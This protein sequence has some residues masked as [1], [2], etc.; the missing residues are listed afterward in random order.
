[1]FVPLGQPAL[2]G[3]VS[4]PGLGVDAFKTSMELPVSVA[5]S[6]ALDCI[7]GANTA[8]AGMIQDSVP[9]QNVMPRDGVLDSHWVNKLGLGQHKLELA[10]PHYQQLLAGGAY[11]T[12]LARVSEL[13]MFAQESIASFRQEDLG[14]TLT[15]E[16][17]MRKDW[18]TGF[19]GQSR[20][21]GELVESIANSPTK[22]FS[23]APEMAVLSSLSFD[24]AAALMEGI[25]VSE[26]SLREKD[27]IFR[28]REDAAAETA[29]A[30]EEAIAAYDAGFVEMLRGARDALR[31]NPDRVRHYSISMREL[32]NRLLSTL[33]PDDAIRR[34]SKDPALYHDGKPTRAARV[35]YICRGGKNAAYCAYVDADV[36]EAIR[37]VRD[38]QGM[39]HQPHKRYSESQIGIL[40]CRMESALRVVVSNATA[41]N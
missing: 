23:L 32:I 27:W 16:P 30:L 21:Y 39:P 9:L 20:A 41:S 26:E 28:S 40:K 5:S 29:D 3:K 34:W 33:A 35:R 11:H 17:A 12:H 38:L 4:I 19:A 31:D 14:N 2:D 6:P 37:A 24:S 25:S 13:T 8:I 36:R 15:F 10:A 22:L 7:R 1:L 18:A